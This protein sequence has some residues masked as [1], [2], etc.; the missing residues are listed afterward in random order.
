MWPFSAGATR[1][2]TRLGV[3]TDGASSPLA[4]TTFHGLPPG[5][6]PPDLYAEPSDRGH[7]QRRRQPEG[8]G[9]TTTGDYAVTT[10]GMWTVSASS[11]GVTATFHR[12]CSQYH[13][14]DHRSRNGFVSA[15]RQF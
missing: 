7:E 2:S 12:R 4:R 13:R 11:G 3:F 9:G 10:P 8:S 6:T 14:D 15:R 5:G 1:M